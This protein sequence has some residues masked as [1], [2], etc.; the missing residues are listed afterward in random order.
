MPTMLDNDHIKALTEK[1]EGYLPGHH[2]R[3]G[4]IALLLENQAN[5]LCSSLIPDD[6]EET[7]GDNWK[8]KFYRALVKAWVHCPLIDMVSVQ[9]LRRPSDT[10]GF[11]GQTNITTPAGPTTPGSTSIPTM[12]LNL[13][14]VNVQASIRRLGVRIYPGNFALIDSVFDSVM[15]ASIREVLGVMHGAGSAAGNVLES[16]YTAFDTDILRASQMVHKR[17]MRGPANHVIGNEKM[18]E[19]FSPEDPDEWDT[20]DTGLVKKVGVYKQ[21]MHVYLDPLFPDG[22]VMLW[23]MGPSIVDTPVVYSPFCYPLDPMDGRHNFAIYLNHNIH[24]AHPS[25]I[26]VVKV[27]VL[28]R[29]AQIV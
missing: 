20:T 23:Y 1:W 14:T 12:T 3:S 17:C 2:K 21:R 6:L 7:Y 25:H 28:E 18:L 10:I 27:N 5:V 22:E 8:D 24:V 4:V 13:Q 19:L 11:Y 29:L 9:P 15:L 16:T 26:Q